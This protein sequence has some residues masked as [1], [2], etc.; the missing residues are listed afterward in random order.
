MEGGQIFYLAKPG[1]ADYTQPKSYR[2]ISLSNYLLKALEKLAKW[3]ADEA[4]QDHPL[5]ENQHGFRTGRG[6]DSAIS[7]LTNYVERFLLKDEACLAVFLDIQAR[8]LTA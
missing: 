6:T 1:K 8:H 3:K 7:Q 2:P 4:L 5:H